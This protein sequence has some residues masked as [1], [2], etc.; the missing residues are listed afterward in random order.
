MYY[1]LNKCL[2]HGINVPYT[3]QTYHTWNK[4]IIHGTNVSYTRRM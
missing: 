3:E 1:T 4:C 2:V